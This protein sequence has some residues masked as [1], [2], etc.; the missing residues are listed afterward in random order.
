MGRAPTS[1]MGPGRTAPMDESIGRSKAL[2]QPDPRCASRR[3]ILWGQMGEAPK[4]GQRLSQPQ[5]ERTV[6]LKNGSASFVVGSCC[7]L[8]LGAVPFH[9]PRTE[10][11]LAQ[12]ALVRPRMGTTNLKEL[13][14]ADGTRW[15]HDLEGVPWPRRGTVRPC[16]ALACNAGRQHR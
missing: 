2:C 5:K 11:Y 12:A 4:E 1:L 6:Q 8:A 13:S 10:H 15:G 9:R 3:L 16:E 7:C 14:K